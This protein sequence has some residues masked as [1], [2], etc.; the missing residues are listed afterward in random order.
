MDDLTIYVPSYQRHE[1]KLKTLSY[2]DP[3]IATIVV[4]KKEVKQYEKRWPNVT[5]VT[6]KGI[7]AVRAW[8]LQNSK[9]RYAMML[10]D[11]LT[12]FW[13]D[14]GL[15]LH[16]MTKANFRSMLKEVRKTLNHK[17]HVGISH[18]MMNQAH[19]KDYEDC[20]RMM[21]A[22]A[23][24]TAVIKRL[25][26]FKDIALNRVKVM[27]DFDLTLQLLRNGFPNRV[28]YKYAWNQPGSNAPGGCSGYRTPEVQ[29]KAAHTLK[30]LHPDFV[31]V[32]ERDSKWGEGMAVRTDVRVSWAKAAKAGGI[33]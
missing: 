18:R 29:A 4:D 31:T 19:E 26:Q 28:F 23:Y 22:Y 30:R 1:S 12:F 33:T 27:E 14:K 5:P 25:I 13:R 16:E 9:T 11:D 20:T 8:I 17:A 3:A 21:N 32:V 10:D 2:L 6:V 15:K 24:D 7:S